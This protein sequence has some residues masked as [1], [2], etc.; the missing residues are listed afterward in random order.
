TAAIAFAMD[1]IAEQLDGQVSLVEAITA[2]L[3]KVENEGL[4]VLS[5]HHGHPG[6]LA[7]P[8]RQEIHSA[9]NRY[10][11]LQLSS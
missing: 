2:L 8:R 11:H 7:L 4:E 9:I 1:R 10:R 5:P 3:A 6:H